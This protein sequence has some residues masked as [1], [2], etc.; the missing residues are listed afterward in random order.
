ML[1]STQGM[2]RAI[3]YAFRT[4]ALLNERGSSV[5]LLS[6]LRRDSSFTVC[7]ASAFPT[8]PGMAGTMNDEDIMSVKNKRRNRFKGITSFCKAFSLY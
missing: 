3:W 5:G 6:P 4:L 2:S 7:F 8:K 1:S